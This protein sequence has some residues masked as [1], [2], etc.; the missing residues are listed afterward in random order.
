MS[1]AARP[2]APGSSTSRTRSG[3]S[4][5]RSSTRATGRSGCATSRSA[6]SGRFA[7][8][9]GVEPERV[10]LEH[11]GLNH[12][13][14]IRAV[15][16]DGVDRLPEI[17]EAEAAELAKDVGTPAEIVRLTRSI[18]SYYLKYYYAFDEVLV[19]QR[20]GA[21]TRAAEVMDIEF[22][23]LTM[24]RNPNLD[25]KPKLLERAAA[26]STPRRPRSSSRRSTTDGATS[27]SSTCRNG[28]R[29]GRRR[30]LPE[31]PDTAVVEVPARI[32]REGAQALPQAPLDPGMR[33][34]VQAVKA[35]EELAIAAARTGD[36]G[37][38]LKALMANPLVAHWSIAAPSS[39]PCSR[40]I[41]ATC[42]RSIRRRGPLRGTVWASGPRVAR[43]PDFVRRPRWPAALRQP[44]L[45][46]SRA[47][48][49]ADRCAVEPWGVARIVAGPAW[50][51]LSDRLGGSPAVLL[52]TATIAVAGLGVLGLAA[53]FGTILAAN[54]LF[55][56][57]IAGIFPIID[58]RAI[59]AAGTE[60]AGWGRSAWG[61]VGWVASSLA[62]GFAV[63]A[64]GLGVIFIVTA[65]GVAAT[66]LL[67]LG[68][69]PGARTAA[70]RPLRAGPDLS[71]A[72][73]A[74]LPES[75]C[76]SPP[77]RCQPPSTSSPRDSMSWA[78]RP[79]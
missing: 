37:I 73:A 4:P 42:R 47:R 13:S 40:P 3:S 8:R 27:R 23:L 54:L 69:A 68:L 74:G 32:T 53:D 28:G 67:A 39:T 17:L 24:Y 9:F 77:P 34:L 30:A 26:R 38:A 44:V 60:R 10:E 25:E 36:R 78:H 33:G 31:L 56:L 55:G 15:K 20:D 22:E 66:A 43:L 7:A 57:G 50:G 48:L 16:V 76:C 64:W 71:V 6:S 46:R 21:E 2:R 35:Y 29:Q 62:T 45:P 75:G 1:A 12:L 61:S 52:A 11:V 63:Q 72:N 79:A 49:P 51:A 65:M 5:R 19:G 70:E 14:W 41:A 58:A 18:P 59:E